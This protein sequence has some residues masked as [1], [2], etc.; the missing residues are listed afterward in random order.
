[1]VTVLTACKTAYTTPNSAAV[2]SFAR[3]S[4]YCL[5]QRFIQDE[6]AFTIY[7]PGGEVKGAAQNF[8]P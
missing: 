1:V 7:H 5:P 8:T 3:S 2:L 4:M 6:V